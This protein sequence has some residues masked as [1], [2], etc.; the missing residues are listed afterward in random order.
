MDRNIKQVRAISSNFTTRKD[1]EGDLFIEGYFSVFNSIYDMG[2]G[3]SES[4]AP[5]AFNETLNED[6]RCLIDHESRLVLGRNTAGTL[7]LRV[8]EKGLWGRV[9]INPKDQDAMNL[10]AR[11]ERGDVSQCSFGFFILEESTDLDEDAETIHWTVEKVRLVEISVVT[12][13]AY[14]DTGVAARKRDRDNAMAELRMKKIEKWK[15]EM[16]SRLKGEK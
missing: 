1:G 10:Y 12:F 6:I 2:D 3:M 7:E 11:V 14:T 16:L 5:T 9:K 4:I 13:P 8:D 15:A